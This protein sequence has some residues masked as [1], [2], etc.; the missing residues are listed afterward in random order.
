MATVEID[1]EEFL[2]LLEER[3]HLR[4]QV[5]KLQACST[6]LI[7]TRRKESITT[8][9]SEFHHKFGYP[10]RYYNP[11]CPVLEV[12]ESDL[13]FRASLI[14]EEYFEAMESMVGPGSRELED[15]HIAKDYVSRARGGTLV[16]DWPEFADALGDLDYV[17][18]GTR[19]TFGI[20]RL[21]VAF[22]IQ[23][24]NMAK[25]RTQLA[26]ADAAKISVWVKP[27]K[28]PGWKPPNIARVLRDNA[29]VGIE[30]ER[31]ST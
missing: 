31:Q 26:D 8:M 23:E 1:E 20:P 16:V 11:G 4:E 25:T 29:W 6:E 27:A 7:E 30:H 14:T 2:R 13:R 24:A 28:P 21:A 3:D 19:L 9:V 17:I 22:A 5:T 10:V 15:L 12:R 18:E